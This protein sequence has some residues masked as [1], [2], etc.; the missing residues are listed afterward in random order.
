MTSQNRTALAQLLDLIHNKN[1]KISLD[2]RFLRA[3]EYVPKQETISC[4]F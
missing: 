3:Y 4:P 1:N 2:S